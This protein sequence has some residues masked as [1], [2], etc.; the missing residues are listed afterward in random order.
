MTEIAEFLSPDDW[1]TGTSGPRY[2][3]LR[4]RIEQ[5]IQSGLFEPGAPLPAEREIGTLTDLSRV[6]VRRA[7]QDL[8]EGGVIKQIQ[9]SGSF[10]TDAAVK[11]EQS[12]S[13]LT[14]FTEDMARRGFETTTVW[15]ERGLFRPTGDEIEGL[16]VDPNGSVAR[17]SRLRLA[18]GQPM[19]IERASLPEDILPNPLAVDRSLYEVLGQ[20]GH[21]PVRA[22]QRISA[23]NLGEEDA[24]LLG[25]APGSAGLKIERLSYLEDDRVAELTRSVYRGD[26]YDFIAE[27]RLD[28]PVGGQG[29]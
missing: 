18:Q 10:V 22:R 11:V 9:G 29:D 20:S 21:R 2:V 17:L 1:M 25:I 26:T 28:R 12:L 3:R 15:L 13:R 6:T 5:G 24:G 23:I 16:S 8:V 19:A 14:S 27:L 4:K 7:I